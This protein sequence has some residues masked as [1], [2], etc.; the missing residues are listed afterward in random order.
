MYANDVVFYSTSPVAI[1]NA[2]QVL[3]IWSVRNYLEVN[4]ANT[5]IMKFRGGGKLARDYHSQDLGQ[6]LKIINSYE[7]LEAILQTTGCFTKHIKAK[8]HKWTRATLLYQKSPI[9]LKAVLKLIAIMIRPIT[10]HA[11][12][13]LWE[14]LSA[15]NLHSM[16]KVKSTYLKRGLCSPRNARNRLVLLMDAT[17]SHAEEVGRNFPLP[18]KTQFQEDQNSQVREYLIFQMN[19]CHLPR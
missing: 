19:Y 7:H 16:N 5:K 13:S 2:L 6:A 4:V 11:I 18:A 15:A 17:D 9:S 10:T 1:Q 12:S 3:E 14:Q 8:V